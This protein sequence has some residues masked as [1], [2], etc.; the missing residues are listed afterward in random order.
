MVAQLLTLAPAVVTP[1][2]AEIIMVEE[3]TAVEEASATTKPE[4]VEFTSRNCKISQFLLVFL[5]NWKI[6]FNFANA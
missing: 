1:R 3:T 5:H 6:F 4:P 2:E